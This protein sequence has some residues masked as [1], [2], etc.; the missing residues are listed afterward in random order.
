MDAGVKARVKEVSA[1]RARR[2]T[3]WYLDR[4]VR[5]LIL[6]EFTLE[7]SVRMVL[8]LRARGLVAGREAT[9]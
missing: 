1:L 2:Y 6:H 4:G 3:V 7:G 8:S 9:T 5:W